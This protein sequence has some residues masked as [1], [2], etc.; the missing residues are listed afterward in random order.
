MGTWVGII[1]MFCN[2]AGQIAANNSDGSV[3]RVWRFIKLGVAGQ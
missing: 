1:R 2:G 3:P